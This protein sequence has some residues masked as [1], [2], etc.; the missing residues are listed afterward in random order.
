MIES[1]INLKDKKYWRKGMTRE[2]L[3]KEIQEN[4]QTC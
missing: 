4:C 2:K 1:I 3:I